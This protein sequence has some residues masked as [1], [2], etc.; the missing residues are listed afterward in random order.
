MVGH[1][2]QKYSVVAID[3]TLLEADHDFDVHD[4]QNAVP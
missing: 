1:R 2:M 4:L 3:L